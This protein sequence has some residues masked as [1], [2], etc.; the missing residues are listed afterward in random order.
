NGHSLCCISDLGGIILLAQ[1]FEDLVNNLEIDEMVD[2]LTRFKRITKRLNK[3]YWNIEDDEKHGIIVGSLG[4]N[5]AIK[6]FS[7]LDMLFILA[8]EVKEQYDKHEGNGQSKL[9]QAIKE[10]IKKTYPKTIVRGDGQVVVV[11][12]ESLNYTIEVCPAF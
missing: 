3:S 1:S 9:L 11:S 5:T 8:K 10:E 12:F 4:R 6:G 2:I 7:D